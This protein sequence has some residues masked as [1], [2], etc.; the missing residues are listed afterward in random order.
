MMDCTML[1]V[2]KAYGNLG[3]EVSYGLWLSE[4]LEHEIQG[5]IAG[6][7]GARRAKWLVDMIDTFLFRYCAQLQITPRRHL[8]T[9]SPSPDNLARN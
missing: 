1:F 9:H 5:C 2:V 8:F 4:N 7:F 6:E 3:W